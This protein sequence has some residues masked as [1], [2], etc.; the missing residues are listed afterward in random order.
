[1]HVMCKI[2]LLDEESV[3]PEEEGAVVVS[4]RDSLGGAGEEELDILIHEA[5]VV[6]NNLKTISLQENMSTN[7][8]SRLTF[9]SCF[10]WQ[11][12]ESGVKDTASCERV[13]CGSRVS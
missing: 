7:C 10:T 4:N 6:Q 1:M 13:G 2:N 9:E 3:Q 12:C 8:R 5:R 11:S